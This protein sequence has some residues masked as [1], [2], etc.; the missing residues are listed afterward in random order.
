M[1]ETME[2]KTE[3]KK[4]LDMMNAADVGV[5]RHNERCG[6]WLRTLPELLQSFLLFLFFTDALSVQ[7]LRDS[8]LLIMCWSE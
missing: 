5:W 3:T 2:F 4:L 8:R 6:I 7:R 1:K